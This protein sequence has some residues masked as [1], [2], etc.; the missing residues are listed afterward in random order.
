VE[1]DIATVGMYEMSNESSYIWNG[2]V[3]SGPKVGA[4]LTIHQNN[5]S[6]I[7]SVSSEGVMD[8]QNTIRSNEFD[9]RYSKNSINR[10]VKLKTQ[11][12]IRDSGFSVTS[13]FVPMIGNEVSVTTN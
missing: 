11:G 2:E 9:N 3:L 10:V 5:I 6:L 1:G 12:V 13:E 7:A 4:F 8:Q